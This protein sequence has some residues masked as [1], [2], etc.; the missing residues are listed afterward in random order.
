MNIWTIYWM[1]PRVGRCIAGMAWAAIPLGIVALF[2]I[3]FPS[4]TPQSSFG[5]Q[6]TVFSAHDISSFYIQ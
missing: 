2:T 6:T 5:V 1:L 3:F 4:S